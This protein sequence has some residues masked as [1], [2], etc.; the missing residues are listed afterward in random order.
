MTRAIPAGSSP[1]APH[2]YEVSNSNNLLEKSVREDIGV[3]AG[4]PKKRNSRKLKG[5]MD[6]FKPLDLLK[7]VSPH[8][9]KK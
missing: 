2:L 4:C 5:E 8:V 6:G 3:N 7:G 1:I 9:T